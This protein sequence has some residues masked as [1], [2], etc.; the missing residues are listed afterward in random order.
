MYITR[1]KLCVFLI[2]MFI[3]FGCTEPYFPKGVSSAP[4]ILVVDAFL[5]ATDR[6]VSVRLSKAVGLTEAIGNT[7]LEE[8]PMNPIRVELEE[9]N[10]NTIQLS[11]IG[12]GSYYAGSLNLDFEKRYRLNIRL[13]NNKQ[14]RSEFVE[15]QQVPKI[16]EVFF[17]ADTDRLRILVNTENV[18]GKTQY[19]RWFYDETFEY[20]SAYYSGFKVVDGEA[21]TRPLDEQI[22][23]CYR[24]DPSQRI[25]IGSTSDLTSNAIQNFEVQSI[26]R[27]SVKIAIRYSIRVRQQSLSADAYTYWYN[28]KKTT[29]DLGGL[30]DPMPGE[31]RGNIYDV[32]DAS[33]LVVGYFSASTTEEERIMIDRTQLPVGYTQ[34]PRFSNCQLDTIDKVDVDR[35]G[36]GVLIVG[37]LYAQ[38]SP[39]LVGYTVSSNSCV[40]CRILLGGTTDKPQFWP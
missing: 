34:L 20:T 23:R 8:D 24:T 1:S 4:D 26:D 28:L 39:E 21:I 40:D 15:I 36:W 14:Y 32:S 31:V 35:V 7:S 22:F 3:I 18:S 29:E 19:F 17:Y 25:L 2:G 9:E 38:F 11:Q 27:T 5:D 13:S 6:S 10:G 12:T 30:F 16:E 33:E 37:G